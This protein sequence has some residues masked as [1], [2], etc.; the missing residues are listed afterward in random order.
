MRGWNPYGFPVCTRVSVG[1]RP[2]LAV[3][4]AV[5]SVSALYVKS[6][7]SSSPCPAFPIVCCLSKL[8]T[9]RPLLSSLFLPWLVDSLPRLCLVSPTVVRHHPPPGT[10]AVVGSTVPFSVL[11]WRLSCF[12]KVLFR[13][14]VATLFLAFLQG[15]L[16]PLL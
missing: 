5:A 9:C 10:V 8:S 12:Y 13:L 1:P 7:I 3:P 4:S 2:F 11:V 14:P 15:T 16:L 6:W